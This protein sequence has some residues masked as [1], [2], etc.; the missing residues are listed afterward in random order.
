MD[1]GKVDYFGSTYQKLTRGFSLRGHPYTPTDA[2]ALSMA[3]A[4]P[5]YSDEA[6][7]TLWKNPVLAPAVTALP[8]SIH[9]FLATSKGIEL[10]YT[11]GEFQD[12]VAATTAYFD[13][14]YWTAKV[15]QSTVG[16]TVP[17]WHALNDR[18]NL[19]LTKTSRPTIT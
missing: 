4:T 16:I 6:Y 11:L 17:G 15:L 14:G 8:W 1:N 13:E 12:L 3:S 7:A 5:M 10:G 18:T 9:Q 2:T 19:E